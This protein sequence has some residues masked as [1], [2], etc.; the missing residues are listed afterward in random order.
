MGMN[1]K[2]VVI[3]PSCITANIRATL[4]VMPLIVLCCCTT[5]EVDVDDMVVEVVPSHQSSFIFCYFVTDVR[6]GEV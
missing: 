1:K 4:K 5:S 2:E 3:K 6:R